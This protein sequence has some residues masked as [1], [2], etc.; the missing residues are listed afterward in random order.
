M[1]RSINI[2]RLAR[3]FPHGI[4]ETRAPGQEVM[5]TFDDGPQL[6]VLP[7][8]LDVLASFNVK[9]TF[10]CIGQRLEVNRDIARRII[11]EGHALGNH[12][13]LH[14]QFFTLPVDRQWEEILRTEE[15]IASLNGNGKLFRP[16]QGRI[17]A[18]LAAKLKRAGFRI[19]FWNVDSCDYLQ[20]AQRVTSVFQSRTISPGDIL[21]MHDDHDLCCEVLKY[22]LPRWLDQGL[23]FGKF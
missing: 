11:D 7:E 4:M 14:K 9:A 12:S 13:F 2:G 22:W 8:L 18:V 3:W 6:H 20:D 16:P 23:Q 5:L 19:I 10:F 1:L 15:I 17:N 21:L